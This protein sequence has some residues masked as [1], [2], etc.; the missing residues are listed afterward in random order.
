MLYFAYD[1]N[2][3]TYR[4]EKRIGKTGFLGLAKLKGYK[5]VFN[6]GAGD[7][8]TKANIQ[9]SG[10]S[11]D[12]VLGVLFEINPLRKSDLD[13]LEDGYVSLELVVNKLENDN[14][15]SCFSY[16]ANITNINEDDLPYDWYIDL[17]IA[18]A[19]EHSFPQEYIDFIKSFKF[20]V[21]E[22]IGLKDTSL[23]ILKESSFIK[24]YVSEAIALVNELNKNKECTIDLSSHAFNN[25]KIII[26]KVAKEISFQTDSRIPEGEQTNRELNVNGRHITVNDGNTNWYFEGKDFLMD[27]LR[28]DSENLLKIISGKLNALS[29]VRT[30]EFDNKYLRLILPVEKELKF[31]KDYECLPYTIEYKLFLGLFKIQIKDIEFHC[32]SGQFGQ[33]RFLV[34]DCLKSIKLSEFQ[35]FVNIILITYAFVSGDYFGDEGYFLCYKDI[36]FH[37]PT[38]ILY[39]TLGRSVYSQYPVFT[40]NGYLAMTTQPFRDD[41]AEFTVDGEKDKYKDL[42][43]FSAVTFKNICTLASENEKMLRGLILLSEDQSDRLEKEIPNLYV[44]L[45]AITAVSI[46]SGNKELKPIEDDELSSELADRLKQTLQQFAIEKKLTDE[47]RLTPIYKKLM[48]L[49]SPPNAD[50]LSKSF[51]VFSYN[52]SQEEI[53]FLKNR[54]QFLHGSLKVAGVSNVDVKSLYYLSLRLRFLISVLVLKMAGFSGRIINYAKLYDFV[55]GKYLDEDVLKKI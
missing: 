4:L 8:S 14:P 53:D 17:M 37:T 7:K 43:F 48:H 34:M 41:E 19:S 40:T 3:V 55:T 47:K 15:V 49:N 27:N 24:K 6:K 50:K 31:Y 16:Q 11:E 38:G 25:R 18:G 1:T 28:Y 45:E 52:L 39:R 12:V 29:S 20:K 9:V 44:V 36:D 5:L 23:F 13:K 22:N 2:L 32:F 33:K 54:D 21:C 26:S 30:E 35:E 10:N 51:K 46:K 42:K